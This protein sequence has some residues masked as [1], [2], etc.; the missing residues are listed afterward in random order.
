MYD[1]YVL[2]WLSMYTRFFALL[3]QEINNI[4]L[5]FAPTCLFLDFEAAADAIRDTFP[6]IN[7]KGCF[8]HY[9]H[10]IWRKAQAT[11]LQIP[12]K[13]GENVK[14]L[15][16]RAAVLPLAPLDFID[17]VWFHRRQR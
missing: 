17:D 13:D 2:F 6:G 15:V 7:T 12:Y 1:G 11:G 16:R 5:R 9:I 3:Q 10:C 4:G 14:N 8:F